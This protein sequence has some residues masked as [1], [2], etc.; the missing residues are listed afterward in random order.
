MAFT[1]SAIKAGSA[2]IEVSEKGLA[3]VKRKL[4]NF[5]RSFQKFG[6]SISSTGSK[7]FAWA[8]GGLGGLGAAASAFG[9]MGDDL[10]KMSQRTGLAVEGLSE[11]G[12][13]AQRSGTDL[14]QFEAA[15]KGTNKKLL[16]A[17]QNAEGGAAEAFHALGLSVQELQAMHPDERFMAITDAL[18]QI[19]DPAMQSAMAMK[20]FEEQGHA[21]LPMLQEGADGLRNLRAE[22]QKKGFVISGEEAAGAAAFQDAMLDLWTSVKMV[23][24]QIGGALAPAITEF[25]PTVVSVGQNIAKFIKENQGLIISIGKVLLAVAGAGAGLFLIGKA[26]ALVGSAFIG[27]GAIAGGV[28]SAI[29]F[30]GTA[31]SVLGSIG[32]ALMAAL[33]ILGSIIAFLVSPIGLVLMAVTALIGAFAY[34]SWTASEVRGETTTL[35]EAFTDM[36]ADFGEAWGG[37]VNAVLAG[38]LAL[39][40]KIVWQLIKLEFTRGVNFIK[41]IWVAW[42]DGFKSI[43]IEAIFG[44]AAIFVK[45]WYSVQEGITRVTSFFKDAW[46]RVFGWFQEMYHKIVGSLG[47]A[48]LWAANKT[49]FLSDEEYAA[50]SQVF[51]EN[52]S[53]AKDQREK[54][55]QARL[56]A[57]AEEKEARLEAI[58]SEEAAVLDTLNTMKGERQKARKEQSAAEIAALQGE[59]NKS[60]AELNKLTE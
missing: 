11:L 42:K 17:A 4:Q 56:D 21:M 33:P 35:R 18:S 48:A 26:I 44:T 51:D 20:L 37:I 29:G 50:A 3:N 60:R 58:E 16:E 23:V 52:A 9:M 47:K 49:G 41:E 40:L 15:I 54:D 53:M 6:D 45:G 59:V 55:R 57:I 2:F 28:G 34:F 7:M 12:Y 1:A 27:I 10:A 5:G 31:F 13:A 43:A 36:K 8:A 24:F 22:A 30:I 14:T 38:D 39:A 25:I 19:K 32:S 46:W